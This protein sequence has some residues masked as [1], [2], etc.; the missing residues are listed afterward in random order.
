MDPRA[1]AAELLDM[2]ATQRVV[3]NLP[4]ELLPA[5][6]TEAYAVQAEVVAGLLPAGGRAIGYKCA[7]TSVIAQQA[8]AIDGPLFG[9]VLEH[10][11]SASGV[12][13]PA[14]R[15]VHRVIEPEYGFRLGSD[16]EPVPGGHTPASV[17]EHIDAIIP[18]IEIVDHRYESWAIGA[19]PI[20]ADNAIHGWWIHG[21]PVS[22]WRSLDLVG[23]GGVVAERNGAVVTTG[24]GANV[25]GDP[26]VVMAWLADELPRFGRRL[27][28]GDVVTTG[29]TTDVFEAGAGDEIVARFSGVGEVV[30]S[31]S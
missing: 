31:F 9:R 20:A 3:R 6:L 23:D 17:A 4:E 12:T 24:S 22:D 27:R 5:D 21:E 16:V 14:D 30:V 19:L 11:T 10:T 13:L 25:L 1:A 28:A 2:R 15:F 18:A 26:L 8:L 7:C 29:V